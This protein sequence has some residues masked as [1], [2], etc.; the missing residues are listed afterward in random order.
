[1]FIGHYLYIILLEFPYNLRGPGYD[2][3]RH[4]VAMALH[5]AVY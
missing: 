1:M 2:R 4:E 3:V 5:S